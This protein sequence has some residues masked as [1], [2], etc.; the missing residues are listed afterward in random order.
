M[1]EC[2]KSDFLN[3]GYEGVSLKDICRH[4]G[5]TTGAFYH[6]FH[7]KD[8]LLKAV[9]EPDAKRFLE[10]LSVPP[11][12]TVSS[13]IPESCL[14]FVYLHLDVF[15]IV[16]RCKCAPYYSEFY[17]DM[18]GVVYRRLMKIKSGYTEDICCLLSKAYVTSFFEII[19]CNYD[20]ETAR[21]C[22]GVL[23]TFFAPP[24]TVR[25]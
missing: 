24:P 21:K 2:A 20:F 3:D 19:R 8:D 25:R 11:S 5:V 4:A 22:I 7:G 12:D 1:I 6:R 10:M 16:V 17:N 14:A 9:V 18:D 23:E 15:K 13:L